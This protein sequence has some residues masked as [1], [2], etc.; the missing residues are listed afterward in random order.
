MSSTYIKLVT[1]V[2][3]YGVDDDAEE[4]VAG[5]GKPTSTINRAARILSD[6]GRADLAAG[7]LGL[8]TSPSGRS[9]PHAP[10]IGGCREYKINSASRVVIP[11]TPYQVEPGQRV[12]VEFKPG[13]VFISAT[14]GGAN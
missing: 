14:E 13:G 8:K 1:H 7:L 3:A 10:E 12:I 5:S 6:A 9:G 2:L 11:L 4:I